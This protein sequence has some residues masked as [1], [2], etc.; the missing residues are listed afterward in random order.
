ME[1]KKT[2]F[3]LLQFKIHLGI[4][5][6]LAVCFFALGYFIYLTQLDFLISD[7]ERQGVQQAEMVAESSV[8]PIQRESYYLLE[9][10]AT[11][12]EYSPLVAYCDIVD[13]TGK[14]FLEGSV[15]AG[16]TRSDLMSAY[17]E[18]DVSLIV[19]DVSLAGQTIGQVKLG[20]FI[21]K[22]RHEVQSTTVQ[23]VAAF[24]VVLGVIAVFLY[25]FLNRLL[26]LPVVNLSI[27]TESLSRGEFV[28]TNLDRRRDELGVLANG[29]NNMSRSLKELY[30]NLEKKVEAR[31]EDLNNAYHEL[32]AIFDN[33]LV[34]IATLSSDHRVI[35]ANSRFAA[36]FGYT[37]REI[38]QISPEKFHVSGREFDEFNVRFY[39]RLAETEIVQLEY[40]FR[41][42][43]GE[44]FWSQVSAKAIDPQNLSKGIIF[45]LEDISDRK[46]ASELLRQ[47]AEDLRI[48]KEDAD[49]A[50]RS[51]SEFLARMSHEIRTPMNAILGMAEMLQETGLS[52]DQREYVSTFSSAGELLLGI[53][54]DILDF[55]KIEVGQIKLE[56]IPFNLRDLVTDVSKLFIYRAEE[57]GLQLKA[58]VA[59]GLAPRYNGDPTRIRQII[60]N[61]LGNAVKFTSQG[62]VELSVTES[63]MDDGA[64]CCLFAVKDSGI[65][66]AKD[67]LD[68]I[69]DS[70]AQADS[71]TTR[72][73][74][75]TGLGLAI[76]KKLAE[77]MGGKIW[78]ESAP[79]VGTTFYIKLPLA[80]DM[81][82]QQAEFKSS[83]PSE[84]KLLILEDQ[85]ENRAS[86]ASLVRS[87]GLGPVF[88]KTAAQAVD[89]LNEYRSEGGFQA[90]IIDSM[91]DYEPGF[92]VAQLLV[93]QG[94]PL[95]SLILLVD[96]PE[97]IVQVQSAGLPGLTC[98][99]KNERNAELLTK[100]QEAIAEFQRKR[101]TDFRDKEWKILL[102]DDVEA[103]RRVVELFLKSSNVSLTHAE[104]GK[105][106]VELF[107]EHPYDLVLMDMEMPVMDGLEATRRIRMWEQEKREYRTPIV[108]L[109]AHAFQEHRHKTQEAGCSEFLAKPVKKQALIDIIEMYAGKREPLVGASTP[110]VATPVV[111]E[112]EDAVDDSPVKIDP[113]LEDL[114]PLFLRTVRDFQTK[115]ADAIVTEDFPTLQRCGHSLKGLGSTYSVDE[116]SQA[117]KTIEAA[118]KSRQ[119]SVVREALNHLSVFM[120]TGQT[121]KIQALDD[122]AVILDEDLPE[123]TGGRFQVHVAPEMS[124]LIP[125]LMDAMQKDLE[126]MN[127]ALAA[128][129]YPTVRRFGHSH[130]GFGSTYGFDYI[131]AAGRMIQHAAEVR[132]EG[133]LRGLLDSLGEYLE[134]VDI[135]FDSKAEV[136]SEDYA[137]EEISSEDVTESPA[138]EEVVVEVDAELYELV[139]LFLDTMRTNIAEMRDALVE[140]NYDVICRHGHSQKGLGSTYG[141]DYLGLVGAKI[142]AAGMQKNDA[143]VR[144]LLGDMVRY[145]DRVRVVTRE[146]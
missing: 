127:K 125:F 76:S 28:T 114:R 118:A 99:L 86:I 1:R 83:L 15:Q 139:P 64:P 40:Q 2:F 85:S 21:D 121:P 70:F 31:T 109:T 29:F 3:N 53:I 134:R 38:P 36:I 144:A 62:S 14:S 5:F 100:T 123:P 68:T 51:K 26:I 6:I 101:M 84:T 122:A 87:W 24:A 43:N 50:T 131:T 96:S 108:A 56:S 126:L 89:V 48:A 124:E 110:I 66:I 128:R 34:G 10:L 60:I 23:L 67:K 92:E 80:P 98:V 143:E 30:K 77:L 22:A 91:V 104:N 94:L 54:N 119:G 130:K 106:A 58:S 32:Q 55:S 74:G 93:G 75:G 112:E 39:N 111:P 78:V 116:I 136:I 79:G 133:R 47:H 103:N 13:T 33:S 46:K 146:G 18:A 16:L 132:D 59:S 9:E 20:M 107:T 140:R 8:V 57:K 11:K 35:R 113:E 141:F 7:I 73:F 97:E 42:K 61:L 95:P 129:D 72:E 19:R 69:F 105:I 44:V 45:V 27:L 117:G 71:S 65:G 41:R 120:N 17:S 90:I 115:L 25:V 88:R 12:A 138:D 137:L 142:E 4:Q 63:V 37:V 52:E 82:A 49:K 102:V 81:Q 135:V 145:L